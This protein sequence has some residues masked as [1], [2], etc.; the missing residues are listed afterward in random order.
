M[1]IFSARKDLSHFS[2]FSLPLSAQS[3]CFS[4][5][6]PG[7]SIED[8][9]IISILGHMAVAQADM[10]SAQAIVNLTPK[11]WHEEPPFPSLRHTQQGRT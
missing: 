11:S 8:K 9:Q 5:V 3:R 4:A 7:H 10:N 2:F 6:Q 1:G